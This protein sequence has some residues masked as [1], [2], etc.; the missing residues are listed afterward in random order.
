MLFLIFKAY[1]YFIPIQASYFKDMLAVWKLD[2]PS[3]FV[4]LLPEENL[5]YWSTFSTNALFFAQT[6]AIV[7]TRQYLVAWFVTSW[8]F[9][10]L[11]ALLGTSVMRTI[12]KTF[13]VARYTRL[14]TLFWAFTVPTQVFT[15]CATRWTRLFTT[16]HARMGTN[17][18]TTTML[19]ASLVNTTHATLATSTRARVT[20][21]QRGFARMR[22]ISRSC[23]AGDR[24]EMST[25]PIDF[26]DGLVA[27]LRAAFSAFSLTSV[28]TWKVF[29]TLFYAFNHYG[30]SVT[31]Y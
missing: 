4:F 19:L 7:A 20:T 29:L 15:L 10:H 9:T 17:Q 3:R 8:S 14:S 23:R 26:L 21:F 25:R 31:S 27:F 28:T 16:R 24:D 12:P 11:T 2:E 5:S 18:N 13:L 6:T 1:C 22:T 30:I